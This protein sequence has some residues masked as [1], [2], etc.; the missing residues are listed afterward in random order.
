MPRMIKRTPTVVSSNKSPTIGIPLNRW[1]IIGAILLVAFG[2][3]EL[4]F[5]ALNAIAVV[6][7]VVTPV[8]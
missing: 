1:T 2:G 7:S 3:R 5:S 4:L 6:S 8:P